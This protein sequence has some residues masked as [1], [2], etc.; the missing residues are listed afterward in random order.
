MRSF[1]KTARLGAACLALLLHPSAVDA[2]YFGRNKVRGEKFDFRIL[3]S[4]HFDAYHYAAESLAT[5]DAARMAERWYARLSALLGHEFKRRPLVFYA[6]H[7]DFQQTNVIGELIGQGTGGV[8]ESARSRVIM[9]FTGVYAD[10]D[11][12]L[13][14]EL[15]HVFQYDI[16]DTVSRIPGTKGPGINSLPL[17]LME[18][19]AE[20][21]SLGRNDPNTAMWLRDA[22]LRN[23]LPTIRQLTTDSRFF[24]YRY[25]EALWAYIGGK[26]GDETVGRLYR[27]SLQ[28]GFEPAIKRVLGMSDDSLSKEWHAAIRAT[29][30]P[31][32]ADLTKPRDAG[33]RLLPTERLEP[34]MMEVSPALSPDG[35]YVAFLSSRNLVS[36]DLFVAETRTGRIVHQLTT[37]NRDE[38]FGSLSFINSSGSWSPDGS[39]LAYVTF[40]N[41]DNEIAIFDVAR[42]RAVRHFNLGRVGAVSDVAWGPGG[43]IALSGTS[44][45]ISDIYL[46][47]PRSGRRRRL[48]NDRF[49]DLQ[50]TWSPDGRT[51]AFATDRGTTDFDRLTYGKLQLATIDVAACPAG[52]CAARALPVFHGAKHI[53]PQFA[54]DGRSLF[55]VSDR[56]G[57]SNVYRVS[58]ADGAAYQV[59]RLATGVSGI[60]A[61]SPALT[62]ASRSGEVVFSVFDNAGEMLVRLDPGAT[63]GVPVSP[64]PATHPIAGTLPPVNPPSSRV[65]TYLADATTGLP[66]VGSAFSIRPYRPRFGLEYIGSP[67]VGV[68][69]GGYGT[70][71]GGSVQAFFSDMLND[72][73]IG[74]TLFAG[75]DV[76][77]IGGSAMYLSQGQRLNWLVGAAHIPYVIGGVAGYRDTTIS[78]G[79]GGVRG[80]V[81]EQQLARLYV[82]Q[83]SAVAQYPL[84]PTRRFEVGLSANRQTVG[85]QSL[86]TVVVGGQVVR[87]DQSNDNT[88]ARISYGQATF[89]YV[90]DY[91]TFGFTSPIAG[92][93]YRFEASPV[94]GGLTYGSLLADYRRYLFV[95]PVTVAIRGLHYGRYGADAERTDWLQSVFLGYGSLVRGYSMESFSAAECTPVPGNASACPEFDRLVG[96]RIAVASA[97]LRI[98]L[99][100]PRPLALVPAGFLPLELS[101]FVDAGVAWSRDEAPNLQFSRNSTGRVPVI[102]TGLSARMNLFGAMVLEI[103]YAYPFQRP[104]KGAHFGFQL[105]PGW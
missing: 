36:V 93:R 49:A 45:G 56:D 80:L 95:R 27:A 14:H 99:F 37:P 89:A 102:S 70:G 63:A 96:S 87:Q 23:K 67:S 31:I 44:G 22:V 29:Y 103:Y 98:P 5:T 18:G 76:R 71:V 65:D 52:E 61:L 43:E 12:V 10:N 54:P 55:F 68:G 8:T 40:A 62:I 59:T 66:A 104:A 75:G 42:K 16:A 82:D 17:W 84:S 34:G 77:D 11:H 83:A 97:E 64:P 72:R 25:G 1:T 105:Q 94:F 13:G 57:I 92:G 9:P 15:V 21:L 78:V 100:G 73:L 79:G 60:T 20:Y 88:L 69:F 58:I 90:G 2:Q 47:D 41:G 3:Q 51:I 53:T 46:L 38:H 39:H 19:M 91:S 101:P 48:T 74:A 4:P 85:L 28:R 26:W 32:M 33:T 35:R 50:P 24:P 30:T 6:D 86:Q 7:P 81:Y